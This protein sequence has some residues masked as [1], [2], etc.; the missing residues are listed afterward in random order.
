MSAKK[1]TNTCS[2]IMSKEC[3]P[4]KKRKAYFRPKKIVLK[5]KTRVRRP[6]NERHY[7]RQKNI[8]AK[9]NI[10]LKRKGGQ[11]GGGGGLKK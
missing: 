7:F 1:Q 3:P 10:V 9:K 8:S 6:R 5:R 4:S 11:G 2:G